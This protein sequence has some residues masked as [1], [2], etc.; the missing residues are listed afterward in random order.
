[1]GSRFG[2]SRV[3]CGSH[4]LV[5]HQYRRV[6]KDRPSRTEVILINHNL[7]SR[8]LAKASSLKLESIVTWKTF[9]TSVAVT[10]WMDITKIR[11]KNERVTRKRE[12]EAI[13]RK[14]DTLIKKAYELGEFDGID[15]AL[16]ICKHPRIIKHGHHPW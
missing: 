4:A 10:V 15:V 3:K 9:S 14:K 5:G 6:L 12:N 7:N 16:I 11:R 2:G 8:K 13:N 1:M